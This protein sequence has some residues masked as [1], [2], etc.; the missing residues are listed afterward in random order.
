M[1]SNRANTLLLTLEAIKK[2][3]VF[4]L[5]NLRQMISLIKGFVDFKKILKTAKHIRKI[6]YMGGS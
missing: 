6:T 1:F 3:S 4:S 2:T 5:D